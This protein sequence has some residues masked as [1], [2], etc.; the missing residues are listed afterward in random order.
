M[1]AVTSLELRPK[2]AVVPQQLVFVH[3]LQL[4]L[5][6][7]CLG[8]MHLPEALFETIGVLDVIWV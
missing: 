4:T 6:Q 5:Q 2:Q 7:I 3:L 1:R 8:L